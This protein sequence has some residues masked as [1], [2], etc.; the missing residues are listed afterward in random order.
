MYPI[1][2]SKEGFDE[3]KFK[4][5]LLNICREHFVEG[6][7]LAFAFIV[8]RLSDPHINKIL[9]DSH[10]FAA[11]DEI[12]G[13]KLTIFYIDN[14]LFAKPKQKLEQPISNDLYM[15]FL[16]SLPG[17]LTSGNSSIINVIGLE[18]EI[19]SPF[20]VFFQV[21][22]T[23]IMDHIVVKLDQEQVETSFLEL[24]NL[25][26]RAVSSISEV[27]SKNYENKQEIFNL[28]ETTITQY[29][30]LKIITKGF[31]IITKIKAFFSLFTNA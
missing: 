26:T 15:K 31:S 9:D 29:K 19:D 25:I 14:S 21:D 6:R 5:E 20:V 3:T 23:K 24:K 1:Q 22:G 17:N 8:Y 11:L 13:K 28:I 27:S 12:S 10:Y 2:N 4:D 7:A 30:N 18:S 16:I